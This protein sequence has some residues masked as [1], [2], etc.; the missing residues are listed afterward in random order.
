MNSEFFFSQTSCLTKAKEPSLPSY[1][2]LAG[3]RTDGFIHFS[4]EQEFVLEKY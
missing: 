4:N 3:E 1:L 2:P